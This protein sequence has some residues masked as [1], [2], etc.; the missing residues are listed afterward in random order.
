[1][2]VFELS[3][4]RP[5][6]TKKGFNIDPRFLP[7]SRRQLSQSL[8][9][10]L[11]A[12]PNPPKAFVS[13]SRLIGRQR[14]FIFSK[15]GL[16]CRYR[17]HRS[18]TADQASVMA[19]LC[20]PRSRRFAQINIFCRISFQYTIHCTSIVVSLPGSH[21]LWKPPPLCGL[22]IKLSHVSLRAR[23]FRS[24]GFIICN[25]TLLRWQKQRVGIAIERRGGIAYF[26]TPFCVQ[27]F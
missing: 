25:F 17:R 2:R 7:P 12:I 10:P 4:R 6:L 24:P 20:D 14:Q 18:R 15:D 26:V 5:G 8:H 13:V 16:D 11:V 27:R 9:S 22:P 1:V 3:K 23:L 19:L 21:T